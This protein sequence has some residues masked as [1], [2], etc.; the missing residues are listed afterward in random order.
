MKKEITT[1]NLLFDKALLVPNKFKIPL[2]SYF[3]IFFC[4]NNPYVIEKYLYA[5]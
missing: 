3:L 2:R 4:C 1:I 5:I